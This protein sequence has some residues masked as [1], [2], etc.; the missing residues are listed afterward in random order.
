MPASLIGLKR[1]KGKL[2]VVYFQKLN[3]N[4]AENIDLIVRNFFTET[5]I[6]Y[7]YINPYKSNCFK[8]LWSVEAF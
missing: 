4:K 3:L 6:I 2:L 5:F 7:I 1:V 8:E